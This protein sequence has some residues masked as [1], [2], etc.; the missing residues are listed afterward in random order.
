MRQV[1]KKALS[2]LIIFFVIFQCVPTAFASSTN[3][4]SSTEDGNSDSLSI[5]SAVYEDRPQHL[6]ITLSNTPPW[7][8]AGTSEDPYVI[9]TADQLNEVRNYSSGYFELGNDID[10]DVPPYNTG[11]GWEPIPWFNGTLD[12]KEFEITGLYINRPGEENVGLFGVLSEEAEISNVKIENVNV[13][14]N[15]AVGGLVGWN[16]KGSINNSSV[17]GNVIGADDVYESDSIGGM[18]G[19]NEGDISNS[20]ARAEVTGY[21]LVGGLTGDNEGSINDSFASGNVIGTE[22][23]GGLVGWNFSNGTI[24]N[25]HASGNVTGNVEVGGLVGR[26][27]G[28]MNYSYASGEVTGGSKVGGLIGYNLQV[29]NNAY[30]SGQVSGDDMVG[31]LIGE[32]NFGARIRNSYASGAVIGDNQTGGLVGSGAGVVENSYWDTDASGQSQSAGGEGKTT[33]QLQRQDTFAD[34]WDLFEVWSI[35]GSG[36]YPYF[37]WELNLAAPPPWK[38]DGIGTENQPFLIASA[39]Q[40][41]DVRHYLNAH[42]ELGRDI[43]LSLEYGSEDG[44]EPIGTSSDPFIGI[45]DGKGYKITGLYMNRSSQDEVG[46]FGV[47]GHGSEISNIRLEHIEVTGNRYIGGLVGMNEGDI[48]NVYVSG[49]VTGSHFLG[50]FA[51][52]NAGNINQSHASSKV[53]GVSFLG[54]LVGANDGNITDSYANGEVIASTDFAGGLV[55]SNV[56]GTI[57]NSYASGKVTGEQ[58]AGGLVSENEDGIVTT[59]YWD[60]ETTNQAASAG[61]PDE[62]G[63]SAA[64]MKQQAT[65]AGWDFDRIWA[66][67]EGASYPYLRADYNGAGSPWTGSGTAEDPFI[68]KTVAHLNQMRDHLNAHF[69]LGADINLN[70]LPYNTGEGW[71]PIDWFNGKLDGK[72]F[73]ITGLY[74]N[75][76]RE[77]VVGLFGHTDDV[78]ELS[79]LKLEDVSVTVAD[80]DLVGG[81][82]GYNHGSISYSSISGKVEGYS[83]SGGLVGYNNGNIS[84]SSASVEV[85]G[86]DFLGGLVGA[87]AGN[88]I[89]S[90]AS[91]KVDGVDFLGGLV[92]VSDGTIRNSYATGDVTASNGYA[93]GLVGANDGNISN[94]YAIGKVEIQGGYAGGLISVSNGGNVINSY[95]DKE[96]TKQTTSA[97]SKR[98]YGKSTA[99]MKQ[100]ATFV[101]WDFDNIWEIEENERYPE[102]KWVADARLSGLTLSEGT[103]SPAF[104]AETIHYRASVS[105]TVSTVNITATAASEGASLEVNGTSVKSGVATTVPLQAGRNTVEVVVTAY[106][107]ISTKSY[108]LEVTRQSDDSSSSDEPIT[109]II[110]VPVEAGHIG[111]ATTVMQTPIT[112]ITEPSGRVRD[113]VI[114]TPDRTRETAQRIAEAGQ[115]TA[116]IVI[117]DEGDKVSQ[118]DI[119]ILRDAI[120]ELVSKTVNLEIFTDNIR[121][122]IPQRSLD[123]FEDD[124]FFRVIPIKEESQR[125]EV[126]NR[127]RLEQVVRKA[128]KN[129]KVSVVSRPMTIETNMPNQPVTLI[130]P[131]REVQLPTHAAERATFLQELM[132]FIEHSDGEKRLVR[133]KIVEYKDGLLGIEFEVNKFSTFTILHLEDIAVSFHEAYIQ[134]YEDGTFK[135]SHTVTR[136]EIAAM[137]ALILGFDDSDK[138]AAAL[139]S[140][141]SASHWAA[142]VIAYVKQ[143]G[144]MV[145]DAAGAFNPNAAITRAEIAAIAAR[146]KQFMLATEDEGITAFTDIT[147]HWA[148]LEI[149]ANK[150]AGILN[151]YED[152]TF[153]P[154]G[155]LTRAEAVR[156]MN[157]MFDRGPL[158]EVSIPTFKDVKETHWAFYEVEEAARDHFF[159]PRLEGGENRVR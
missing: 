148:V 136:A 116:R 30:A 132:I 53:E 67:D 146:Y 65:F 23:V 18:V 34:N 104:V 32:N 131:L 43:D 92:G 14:G 57:S 158:Y 85:T 2:M 91:S 143:Q 140:D 86:S 5:T 19:L 73:K 70:V 84:N 20:Y 98:S 155:N 108:T 90:H 8:V 42:F 38:G 64:E 56:R 59:S 88:I 89:Q 58:F 154:N 21:Y 76:S 141:V 119:K 96:T 153:R 97:G 99:E 112:R 137:I 36:G 68:V 16:Y 114:L 62:Y 123:T 122:L 121:L 48:N 94:S 79:N 31:G 24:N 60:Q 54:G 125:K 93:G 6:S 100:Q 115:T 157:R 126:E 52:A 9:T 66:I 78:S 150:Q 26:N 130:L 22:N 110:N 44:W 103:L 77:D 138:A 134:G 11:E 118:V 120:R 61:S 72:G 47:T 74:I 105:S 10:L 159:T 109:E 17:S 37:R 151:G 46:L 106:D 12:G 87:N 117:P 49:E 75:R 156:V 113:E 29:V 1:Y 107:G 149:A 101:D 82:V 139:F 7:N 83:N 45:L 102:L 147:G 35:D 80:Y 15:Y 144:L 63:K 95:W 3:G 152:G 27:A 55:G 28:G 145:G 51:G 127:A 71:E 129:D 69:K 4:P 25:S 13:T 133:G 124:L 128:A 81:L 142:G 33:A 41:N 135:P 40:L 111:S 50:G 39:E